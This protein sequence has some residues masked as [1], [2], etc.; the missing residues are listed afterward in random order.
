MTSAS[1]PH[2]VLICYPEG[3]FIK[4][5]YGD[6][7]K[8]AVRKD[9]P[10][11]QIMEFVQPNRSWD[12]QVSDKA[13]DTFKTMLEN[14]DKC[15]FVISPSSANHVFQL[16]GPTPVCYDDDLR[17]QKIQQREVWY[18]S[19]DRNRLPKDVISES[20]ETRTKQGRYSFATL[21]ISLGVF[22]NSAAVKK[23][24]LQ[25]NGTREERKFTV[26]RRKN[27]SL[28]SIDGLY[29]WVIHKPQKVITSLYNK[30]LGKN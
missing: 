14:C 29:H 3:S 5:H 13:H 16:E 26:T 28:F 10:S 24:E 15:I 23:G 1:S 2:H 18:V 19:N 27:K 22:R 17:E 6:E 20:A 8:K 30:I 12:K 9:N 21:L 7:V 11:L 25:E 4:D